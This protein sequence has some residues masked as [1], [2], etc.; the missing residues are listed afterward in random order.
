MA[1]LGTL[2]AQLDIWASSRGA[3]EAQAGDLSWMAQAS[4]I[5]AD[6]DLFFPDRGDSTREAKAVCR[7]CPVRQECLDYALTTQQKFGVWG[8]ASERERRG[9]RA[10][11]R[12]GQAGRQTGSHDGDH[13]QG[14]A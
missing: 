3:T 14:A 9:M 2:L 1:R 12:Q 10:S 11:R 5:G 4:C 13:G 8:G 6:P 7:G